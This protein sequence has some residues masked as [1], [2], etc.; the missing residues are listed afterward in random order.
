MGARGFTLVELVVTM[1]VLGILAGIAVG[2]VT[3]PIEG[4]VDLS[5]RAAL[6]DAAD[7]ALRRMQRDLRQALPNSIR[8]SGAY[9]ELL[10]TTDGG[11]YRG[12]PGGAGSD[13]LDFGTADTGFDVLGS[14]RAAPAAGD[15]AVVYNLT[16]NG[17]AANAYAG[18]NRAAIAGSSTAGHIVLAPPGL[19]YP[20]RSPT[21]RFFVVDTPVTYACSGGNL[22][23]YDG[24]APAPAQPTPPAGTPAVMATRVSACGFSYAPGT[25][26]RA[27]LVT[28]Q[29][30]LSDSGET[31]TLLHQVHVE[32]AP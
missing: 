32:N 10:H 2:F 16:A 11:R 7:T 9:L 31:V 4:F 13:I 17:A 21:Q 19:R 23:R 30:T 3:R 25:S 28:L 1:V 6:V 29:L 12:Q 18:D 14:L 22:L 26:E 15:W 24:Y 8:V 27:G 5:R 20:F